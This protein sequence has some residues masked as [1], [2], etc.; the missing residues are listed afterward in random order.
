MDNL[1]Q[2]CPHCARLLKAKSG[3][4]STKVWETPQ[5]IVIAGDHQYY[6]GYCVVIA[7]TH[8]REMHHMEQSVAAKTFSDVL[9]VGRTI[10]AAFKSHKMNYVS[11]GNVD[12]HLHWHVMPRYTDDPDH[13]DHPWKNAGLFAQKPTTSD[14]VDNLRNVFSRV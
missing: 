8:I 9:T 2:G 12:E 5:V 7:K 13:K 14:H 6:P 11:L 4:L 10:E 1:K 3:E